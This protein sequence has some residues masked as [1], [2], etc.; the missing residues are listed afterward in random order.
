MLT[1]RILWD[2]SRIANELHGPA[3]VHFARDYTFRELKSDNV[4]LLGNSV[5]R[6]HATITDEVDCIFLTRDAHACNLLAEITRM[7][8]KRKPSSQRDC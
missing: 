3:A 5:R 7:S 6:C 2:L 4:I 1:A 8:R